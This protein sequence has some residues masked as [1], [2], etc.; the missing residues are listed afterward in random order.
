MLTTNQVHTTVKPPKASA[1]LG[2]LWA[3]NLPGHW[4]AQKAGFW[5]QTAQLPPRG[6]GSGLGGARLPA[7]D[8]QLFPSHSWN[9]GLGL[10]A[11][12]ACPHLYNGDSC[13]LCPRE[14]C[15]G[16]YVTE[17]CTAWASEWLA[18]VGG[19][20]NCRQRYSSIRGV[21]TVHPHYR[22]YQHHRQQ[23]HE[24][25]CYFTKPGAG[26]HSAPGGKSGV[27]QGLPSSTQR[28]WPEPVL[29]VCSFSDTEDTQVGTARHGSPQKP[30]WNSDCCRRATFYRQNPRGRM[31]RLTPGGKVS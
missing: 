12:R 29:R 27:E 22:C 30:G 4:G 15:E 18:R 26:R 7:S 16:Y 10:Q 19:T 31:K 24:V 5:R 6:T 25:L 9:P 2:A 23:C 1:G 20:V 21:A 13:S 11:P 14:L 3:E 8:A 17:T 28:P